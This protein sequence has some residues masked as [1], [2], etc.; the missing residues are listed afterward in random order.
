M[1]NFAVSGAGSFVTTR[2]GRALHL[3]AYTQ[4]EMWV[5][6]AGG[7][8]GDLLK[9]E[10]APWSKVVPESLRACGGIVVGSLVCLSS[11]GISDWV[12]PAEGLTASL[13][14]DSLT[15]L[16]GDYSV[17]L[18]G[19][20]AAITDPFHNHQVC[21]TLQIRRTPVNGELAWFR[22]G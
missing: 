3:D 10:T 2:R 20:N 22:I 5:L 21:A 1:Q 19:D 18:C 7:P 12:P 13:D 14:L 9:F 16:D 17:R 6:V 4:E 11:E 8:I 15:L